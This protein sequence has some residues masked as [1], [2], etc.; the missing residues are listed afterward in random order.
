MPSKA[1][2]AWRLDEAERAVL[3]GLLDAAVRKARKGLASLQRNH[4]GDPYGAEKADDVRRR[5][6]KY[7]RLAARLR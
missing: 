1:L 2:P 6:E 3:C 5:I 7:E 4:G